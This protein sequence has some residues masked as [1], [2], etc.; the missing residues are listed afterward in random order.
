[1][2]LA[3][4]R[5]DDGSVHDPPHVYLGDDALTSRQARA[6]AAALVEAADEL[7]RL[8][9][10][11]PDDFKATSLDPHRRSELPIYRSAR[12]CSPVAG[13]L[14]FCRRGT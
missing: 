12:H 4:G 10:V 11:S 1:M 3:D 5:I 2:Q 8:D 9:S 7:D 13:R 14:R 6:L